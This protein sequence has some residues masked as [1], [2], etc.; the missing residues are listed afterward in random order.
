MSAFLIALLVIAGA[1]ALFFIV[2]FIKFLFIHEVISKILSIVNAVLAMLISIPV[3]HS[4]AEA[5]NLDLMEII[6]Y[7]IFPVFL[8]TLAWLFFM[9]EEIFDVT[10][11]EQTYDVE[12]VNDSTVRVSPHWVG[13]FF[14]N[15]IG[16]FLFVGAAY[17]FIRGWQP[18]FFIL[19]LFVLVLDIVF[20]VKRGIN[21][22]R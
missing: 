5:K 12:A 7:I 15:F 10:W 16:A 18:I 4:L 1:V 21:K 2:K 20:L 22:H 14:S 17:L 6:G 9:G 8:M 11:D 19:P 13:G 3:Y